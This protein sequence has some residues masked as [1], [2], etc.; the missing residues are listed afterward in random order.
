MDSD[1]RGKKG[2][3]ANRSLL[4][5]STTSKKNF[6][7][8]RDQFGSVS[9]SPSDVLDQVEAARDNPHLPL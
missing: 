6:P 9:K 8:A 4:G 5:N 1:K 2:K 7:V 3:H